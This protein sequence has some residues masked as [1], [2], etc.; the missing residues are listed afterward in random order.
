MLR[1]V[2]VKVASERT[3]YAPPYQDQGITVVATT[4]PLLRRFGADGPMR[5][6]FGRVGWSTLAEAPA[7]PDGDQLLKQR[8]AAVRRVREAQRQREERERRRPACIRCRAKFSDERWAEQEQA[9]TWD[10]DGLCVGCRQGAQAAGAVA[11]MEEP[12]TLRGRRS[13]LIAL[14]L[15]GHNSNWPQGNKF[16]GSGAL[17]ARSPFHSHVT[18]RAVRRS[19]AGSKT[20][21]PQV[22]RVSDL[23]KR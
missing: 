23:R 18:S 13:L 16:L 14:R 17:Q 15:W 9:D 4:L 2:Q 10:D 21:F 6:R 1:L 20:A 19:T 11:E 12:F 5:H 22:R 8:E 7:M 3:W